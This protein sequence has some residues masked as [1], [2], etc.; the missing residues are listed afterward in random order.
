MALHRKPRPGRFRPRT[1]AGVATGAA[2]SVTASV[3]ALAAPAHAAPPPS[4]AQIRSQVDGLYRE[5]EQAT[6]RYDGAREQAD[7]LQQQVG[8]LQDEL[9]RKA[10]A[11]EAT[12]ARL[13]A[14]AAEQYRSSGLSTALQLALADDPQQFLQRAGMLDQAGAIEQQALQQYGQQRVALD[15]QTA[16]ARSRL[17]ELTRHQQQLAAER[18]TVQQKLAQAQALL[19]EL[20]GTTP[21]TGA[22]AATPGADDAP[23]PADGTASA[24]AAAAIAFARSQLGKPYVWGATGPDAYDCSGLVQAAWQSAGVSLP[25]TTYAQIVAAPRVG[26]GQLHPGDLVFF[27][28]GISHVGLYAGNGRMIHAPRPG[29]PVRYESVDAMPFAGAVRPA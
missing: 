12:R 23:L 9:A 7:A 27:Y 3:T 22:A 24:R 5:A 11:I 21:D 26:R 4:A 2:V 20:T 8:R 29:A 25:R 6:Q 19:A 1:V 18:A 10:A 16:E 28:S 17:A 13:G 14:L 15:A